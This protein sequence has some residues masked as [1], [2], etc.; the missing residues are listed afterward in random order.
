MCG[1]IGRNQAFQDLGSSGMPGTNLIESVLD[2]VESVFD[3]GKFAHCHM[4]HVWPSMDM[5]RLWTRKVK[6]SSQSPMPY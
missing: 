6:K 1:P 3:F 2:L 5:S 4:S